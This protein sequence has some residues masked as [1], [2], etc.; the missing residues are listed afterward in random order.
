MVVQPTQIGGS[1]GRK[2]VVGSAVEAARLSAAV[3]RPVHVGWSREDDLRQGYYR[4]P[5][6]TRLRGSVGEDGESEGRAADRYR[7]HH[8]GGGR[9]PRV[10]R[11][12]LGFDPGGVLGQ[13][14]PYALPAYR[15]V[16]RREQLPVPVRGGGSVC[17]RTPSP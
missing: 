13:F 14:L 5:T 16:N 7:R 15:V 17:S 1:F 8:L 10:R 3:G 11:D 4:P 9:T 2:T 6:H 12:A